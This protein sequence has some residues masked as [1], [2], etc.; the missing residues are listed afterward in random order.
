MAIEVE[1]D[2]AVGG[3]VERKEATAFRNELGVRRVGRRARVGEI[4]GE[5]RGDRAGV[6]MP[7]A[8][9]DVVSRAS[10]FPIIAARGDG[11]ASIGGITR[12]SSPVYASASAVSRSNLGPSCRNGSPCNLNEPAMFGKGTNRGCGSGIAVSSKRESRILTIEDAFLKRLNLVF[13]FD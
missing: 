13:G 12:A 11:I 1:L 4:L 3:V 7:T 8:V 2:V 6:A 5:M 10:G 9:R